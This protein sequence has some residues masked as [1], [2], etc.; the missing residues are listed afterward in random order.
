VGQG[1]APG[2]LDRDERGPGLARFGLERRAAGLCGGG[3]PVDSI[4]KEVIELAGDASPI[5]AH[6][7]ARVQL[8]LLPQLGRSGA[9]PGEDGVA[10]A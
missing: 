5:G 8:A 2:F 10:A 3:D 4:A 6:R 7:E 9:Q 1:L